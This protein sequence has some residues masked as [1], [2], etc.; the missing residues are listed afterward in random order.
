[1]LH[2]QSLCW[3]AL[4]AVQGNHMVEFGDNGWRAEVVLPGGADGAAG[5]HPWQLCADD[6]GD[7]M[8]VQQLAAMQQEVEEEDGEAEAGG[9]R[10]QREPAGES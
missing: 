10:Q 6:G 5:E 1:M 4:A 8:A 3:L 7:A 9:K 2:P